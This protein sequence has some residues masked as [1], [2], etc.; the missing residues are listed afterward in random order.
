[1][2]SPKLDPISW[3]LK[4]KLARSAKNSAR[5]NRARFENFPR[6]PLAARKW[7]PRRC[8]GVKKSEKP[9]FWVWT[10]YRAQKSPWFRKTYSEV[11]ETPEKVRKINFSNL[12]FS[13]IAHF[14]LF[15]V[16]FGYLRRYSSIYDLQPPTT[17]MPKC[18]KTWFLPKVALNIPKLP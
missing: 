14:R 18:R 17:R 8:Q 10:R 6:T 2:S 7:L 3:Y 5:K 9:H 15:S 4:K 12:D 1:M 13:I 16:I 11:R